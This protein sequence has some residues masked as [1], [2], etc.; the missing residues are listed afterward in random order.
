MDWGVSRDAE[1]AVIYR[2]DKISSLAVLCEHKIIFK[3][4]ETKNYSH[5]VNNFLCSQWQEH[6]R[7]TCCYNQKQP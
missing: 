3:H 5:F 6:L 2:F 7:K 4:D 1:P